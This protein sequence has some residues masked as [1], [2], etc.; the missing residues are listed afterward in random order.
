MNKK[1][2]TERLGMLALLLLGS[3][4]AV[5]ANCKGEDLSKA[6][7][8][9]QKIALLERL[10]TNS[11]PLRRA[12]ASGDPAA[13]EQIAGARQI[14]ADASQALDDDCLAQASQLSSDGLKAATAAFK[15]A[16]APDR[17]QRE[18]YESALQQATTFMLSLESQP[19]ELWGLSVDDF[20]GI[21]R[22]IERAESLA[23]NGSFAEASQ[24][25]LPVNDRLQRRL[26]EIFNNKTVYYE[27]TFA[28]PADLYAYLKEQYSGYQ[29]LL[30]SGQKT[31]SY[32]AVRR[33][34]TLLEE[35]SVQHAQA[36]THAAAGQWREAVT[37]MEAAIASCEQA[38]RATGYSY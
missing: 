7:Q 13:L 33:V 36:E 22:Q 27:K 26:F 12:E 3:S 38:I 35:A 23:S 11:E 20:A 1:K 37:T 18:G 2:T 25:L 16:A 6:P 4:A 34:E 28:T 19:R 24:L 9:A 17:Q 30:Q 5:A 32:S 31:A 14:L 10:L 29:M 21:E 8:V 15:A